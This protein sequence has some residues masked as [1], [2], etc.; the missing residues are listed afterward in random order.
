VVDD[1]AAMHPGFLKVECWP[2][3]C[4]TK[5]DSA[6]RATPLDVP[7]NTMCAS[8]LRDLA[9]Q[10]SRRSTLAMGTSRRAHRHGMSFLYAYLHL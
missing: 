10:N 2:S 8:D 7:P 5:P 4:G 3:T 6:T 9:E 1:S